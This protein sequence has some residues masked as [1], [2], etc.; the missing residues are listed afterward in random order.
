ME[1]TP[2]NNKQCRLCSGYVCNRT[3]RPIVW[4]SIYHKHPVCTMLCHSCTAAHKLFVYSVRSVGIQWMRSGHCIRSEAILLTK[5]VRV[6]ASIPRCLSGIYAWDYTKM[7]RHLAALPH[8]IQPLA[9]ELVLCMHS[10]PI[11]FAYTHKHCDFISIT[12]LISTTFVFI[13]S[14]GQIIRK[15]WSLHDFFFCVGKN[16][17]QIFADFTMHRSSGERKT[18]RIDF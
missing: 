2:A 15:T 16:K 9:V 3:A 13:L 6:H 1:Q 11:S 12:T 5:S 10:Y 14:G 8:P 4:K 7:H 17:E 18:L